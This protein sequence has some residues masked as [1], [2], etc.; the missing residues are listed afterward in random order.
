MNFY[1]HHIGDFNNATRHLTRVEQSVYRGAIELYYDTES[2]LTNDLERLA[3]RLLCVNSE[4]KEALKTVLD[5]FFTQTEKGYE[6][7]RCEKEIAK[8]RANTVAKA[9]AGIASAQARRQK[10]THVQ[11]NST[12]VQ[13]NS[14]RVHNQEPLTNNQEP[15]TINT[16]IPTPNG[17]SPQPKLADCPH[18]EILKLWQKHFPHLSQPRIWDGN[19]KAMLKARWCQAAQKSDYSIDGY[20]TQEQGLSWW[21]QFFAYIVSDTSLSKGFES[22][23]R[24]WRPDLPWVCKAENF[25]KIVEGKYDL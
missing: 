12:D 14:T 1:P 11:Q 5:E 15:I 18:A 19:R 24:T 20:E 3:K 7:E 25:A 8:Y 13:Q 10:T 6:H 21:D 9:K 2:A 22:A 23:G 17:V 16:L 4:E